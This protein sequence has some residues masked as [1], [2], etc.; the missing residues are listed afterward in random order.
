LTLY[1]VSDKELEKGRTRCTRSE[2]G[3]R[4]G[5][6]LDYYGKNGW[7]P[8]EE[9]V[10]SLVEDQKENVAVQMMEVLH[11]LKLENVDLNSRIVLPIPGSDLRQLK[12]VETDEVA[13]DVLFFEYTQRTYVAV[14]ALA[15]R[16]GDAISQD[17][18]TTAE[19]RMADYLAGAA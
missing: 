2:M 14:H 19:E 16:K 15:R 4:R 8:V 10:N 11:Q 9:F 1:I 17:D 3:T 5:W 7:V 18:L 13:Y 12:T 6:R